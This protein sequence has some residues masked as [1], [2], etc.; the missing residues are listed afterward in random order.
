MIIKRI[1]ADLAGLQAG[2][3]KLEEKLQIQEVI[4]AKNN[5]ILEKKKELGDLNFKI[6]LKQAEI[7]SSNNEA[8]LL[9]MGWTKNPN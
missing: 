6:A 7:E 9:K 5:S 2:T 3:K 1:T 8:D 4:Q